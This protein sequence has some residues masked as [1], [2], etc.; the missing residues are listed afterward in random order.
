MEPEAVETPPEP[1]T[2]KNEDN[3]ATKEV[4]AVEDADDDPKPK[5]RNMN[6]YFGRRVE[7]NGWEGQDNERR[8]IL[9]TETLLFWPVTNLSP[10][11][12][13]KILASQLL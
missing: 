5:L 1:E 13:P 6:S 11:K 12:S 8:Y 3:D 7:L 2:A 10:L 9:D 4:E